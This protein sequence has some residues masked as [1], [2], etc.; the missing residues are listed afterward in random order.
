MRS[1]A[2]STA[3]AIPGLRAPWHARS[4]LTRALVDVSHS[5]GLLAV[6]LLAVVLR[7]QHLTDIP[8]YTDEINEITPAFDI[9][10]GSS[11]PLMSGPKH[12]GALFDYVLAGA[13]LVF[14]RSPDLPRVVILV[15]GLATVLITYGYARSLG[16]RWAGLLAAGLLAV[17]APHVLLSSRVAWSASLTPL[18]CIGAAWALDHA[19]SRRRPWYLLVAGLLAGLAL[20]AHPSV[21]VLLPGFAGLILLRGRQLLR[22]PQLYLAGLLFLAGFSNVL[23]YNVQSGMG[24]ARSV[25]QEY[26]DEEVGASA[27]LENLAEPAR[28]LILTVASSVDPTHLPTVLD[29]IVLGVAGLGGLALLDLARRRTALP[30]LMIGAAL[31]LLPLLHDEFV[32]LLKARYV[33][34]LVPLVYVALAVFLVGGMTARAHWLRVAAAS[35]SL[36]MLAVLLGSLLQFESVV[37]ARDC[38]NAPQR[39]FVAELERQLQPGEWILLDQGVLPSAERMGYLSLLELSSK[40]VGEAS[41]GRGGVWDELRERPS[42]L[43][44]VSDG[45]ASILFEKQGLPL[46][47]QQVTTVHPALREPGPDGRKPVQGIGLYRVSAAGATLLAYDPQPGCG[48]LFT[49]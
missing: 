18:L 14:G 25:S 35:A 38:T 16:G 47:P 48:D 31:L 2:P 20:Q 44:A 17:S 7:V 21:V 40:K 3:L 19:V 6:G 39:R 8:R 13:M 27:Y 4:W 11:F 23:L 42:F 12:I 41:L 46:L 22:Q 26:P 45:K 28:G 24:G 29:P 5:L 49:N 33:M 30:L 9:V 34:P 37:I 15:A 32:P 36:A 43:T 1:A 10:R